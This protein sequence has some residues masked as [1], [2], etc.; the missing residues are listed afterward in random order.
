MN[1]SET[2]KILNSDGDYVIYEVAIWNSDSLILMMTV[3]N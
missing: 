2:V 3:E 1:T